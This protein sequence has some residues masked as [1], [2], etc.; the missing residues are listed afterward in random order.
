MGE[1]A[2]AFSKWNSG[3]EDRF[4]Q[5]MSS[6]NYQPTTSRQLK[7]D[8]EESRLYNSRGGLTNEGVRVRDRKRKQENLKKLSEY[9][10]SNLSGYLIEAFGGVVVKPT[11]LSE[12][13]PHT[14]TKPSAKYI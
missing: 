1:D 5:G 10:T 9:N 6:P 12:G 13:I 11:S 3:F 7:K 4:K 8:E 14:I 2:T